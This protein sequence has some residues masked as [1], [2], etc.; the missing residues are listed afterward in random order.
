VWHRDLLSQL[1]RRLPR[2]RWQHKLTH[3]GG[4]LEGTSSKDKVRIEVSHAWDK[5]EA[6]LSRQVRTPSR[7]IV[8][9]VAEPPKPTRRR[10]FQK[11]E[12]TKKT[13][14]PETRKVPPLRKKKWALVNEVSTTDLEGLVS[15]IEQ[16]CN[17]G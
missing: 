14:P 1:A 6:G 3:R 4:W 10:L 15:N 8:E 17:K 7:T 9:E 11:K 5:W 12:P 16:F 2:W 13:P